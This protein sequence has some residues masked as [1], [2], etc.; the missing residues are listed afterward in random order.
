MKGKKRIWI[1][2]S[3]L[4]ESR[5]TGKTGE[6]ILWITIVATEAREEATMIGK[7]MISHSEEAAA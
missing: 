6:E 3:A 5:D 1:T 7:M 4:Q 2:I